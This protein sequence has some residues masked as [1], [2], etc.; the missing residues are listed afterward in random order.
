[1]P[2]VLIVAIGHDER[3]VDLVLIEGRS[4]GL[5]RLFQ[6]VELH[7]AHHARIQHVV[8]THQALA[9]SARQRN[10]RRFSNPHPFASCG[11]AEHGNVDGHLGENF[12]DL[13]FFSATIRSDVALVLLSANPHHRRLPLIRISEVSIFEAAWVH[14]IADVMIKSVL[15]C[16]PQPIQSI[17]VS[18]KAPAQI[19]PDRQAKR[20][21]KLRGS[22]NP[23]FARSHVHRQKVAPVEALVRDDRPFD[24]SSVFFKQS[25]PIRLVP[26]PVDVAL[27]LMPVQPEPIRFCV[28]EPNL[29]LCSAGQSLEAS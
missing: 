15:V 1:M 27:L 25:R 21:R 16:R 13:S 28:D 8:R 5:F 24:H 2:C 4:G 18:L 7:P 22:H 11:E 12:C 9:I 23:V 20:L 19:H 26:K 3:D 17:R 29:R 6:L 14:V 10:P